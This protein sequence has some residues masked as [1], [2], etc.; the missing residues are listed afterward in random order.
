MAVARAARTAAGDA[1]V[2]YV[3]RTAV[4]NIIAVGMILNFEDSFKIKFRGYFKFQTI[5][6][7]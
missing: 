3:N 5:L 1:A 6:S 7:K 4:W 2:G